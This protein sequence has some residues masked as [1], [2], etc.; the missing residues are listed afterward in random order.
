M[1]AN[2]FRRVADLR[3]RIGVAFPFA[4]QVPMRRAL[5]K[6]LRKQLYG[7]ERITV[8]SELVD[9]EARACS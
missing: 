9:A 2:R 6:R 8:P 4:H 5:Y 1:K 3:K 7:H